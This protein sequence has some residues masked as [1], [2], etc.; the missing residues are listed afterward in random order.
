MTWGCRYSQEFFLWWIF[1]Q[2]NSVSAEVWRFFFTRFVVF[3]FAYSLGVFPFLQFPSCA[4][5]RKYFTNF[6][7]PVGL[8]FFDLPSLVCIQFRC[9]ECGNFS[10]PLHAQMCK[11]CDR[12]SSRVSW[13]SFWIGC[14]MYIFTI[15][16]FLQTVQKF[17]IALFDIIICSFVWLFVWVNN[18]S[19]S[20][21]QPISDLKIVLG[22]V[23]CSPC[24]V[25]HHRAHDIVN[26]EVE[27]V[28]LYPSM[29]LQNVERC[30][31]FLRT[32]FGVRFCAT[33]S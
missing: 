13:F 28:S 33:N 22:K 32:S 10:D 11:D 16:I 1:D 23:L 18:F 21:L 30:W 17:F 6:D 27:K 7:W 3:V 5:Y 31:L 20:L 14:T 19:H 24:V 29:S 25:Q 2:T 8:P 4:R 9:E 12:A 15:P 26:I